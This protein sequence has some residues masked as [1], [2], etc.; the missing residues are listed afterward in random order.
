LK[1]L[2][3]YREKQRLLYVDKR[4]DRELIAY[5]DYYLES[6]RIADATD[7]YQ[8]ANH[9]SGL[10][11]IKETAEETGD[12]MAFQHVLKALKTNATEDDW[13][14]IGQRAYDLKKYTFAL[15]AFEKGNAAAKIEQ[16]KSMIISEDQIKTP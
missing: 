7:F 11:K 13:N 12:V 10:E 3:D 14:R 15:H 8:K 5:G 2:P 9:T 4:S 16:V 6:G 1:K